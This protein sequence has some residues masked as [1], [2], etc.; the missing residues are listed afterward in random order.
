MNFSINEADVQVAA[1]LKEQVIKLEPIHSVEA[2]HESEDWK[3]DKFQIIL[4]GKSGRMETFE[5]ST[6]LGHRLSIRGDANPFSM[7]PSSLA[8]KLKNAA[9]KL[10]YNDFYKKAHNIVQDYSG[11]AKPKLMHKVT[12]QWIIKPTQASVLYSLISDS[13]SVQGSFNDFCDDLG[14]DS[15]S[16]AAREIFESCSRNERKLKTIF[17]PEQISKLS[18]LLEDY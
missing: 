13:S 10:G 6:G 8:R 3:H 16:I 11:F 4:T 17:S 5:Y 12:S 9:L 7:I 2:T 1:Y 14:Y 15:D 18:G